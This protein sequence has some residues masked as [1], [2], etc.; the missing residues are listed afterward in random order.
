MSSLSEPGSTVLASMRDIHVHRA[1]E[2]GGAQVVDMG[3]D[4]SDQERSVRLTGSRFEALSDPAADLDVARPRRR[5]VLIS[6]NP[7]PSA[8]NHEGSQTRTALKEPPTWMWTMCNRIQ[9][10]TCRFR[11][12]TEFL[13]L[14][15]NLAE[16][17]STRARLMQSVPWVLRGAFRTA[18]KLAMPEL[19]EGT[20]AKSK[21]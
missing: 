14:N 21:L 11:N 3:V 16:M 2:G 10:Q 13:V 5:F 17:F 12:H 4:D 1:L 8:S 6:Q 18:V 19:L 7:E 15:T 20:E 9:C